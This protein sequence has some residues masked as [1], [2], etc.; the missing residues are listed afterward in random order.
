MT[1]DK[2]NLAGRRCLSMKNALR[3]LTS[4]L[5][6]PQI[7]LD[8]RGES[9]LHRCLCDAFKRG[10]LYRKSLLIRTFAGSAVPL[11]KARESRCCSC[12]IPGDGASVVNTVV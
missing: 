1:A 11:L 9:V 6:N 3:R 10:G 5:R 2:D 4:F 8:A 7:F 12:T